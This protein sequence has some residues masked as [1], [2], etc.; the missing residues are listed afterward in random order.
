MKLK[1]LAPEFLRGVLSAKE[2]N[3]ENAL[4]RF[5]VKRMPLNFII[6]PDFISYDYTGLP[7]KS[8]KLPVIA[9]TVVDDLTAKKIKPFADNIIFENF[10]PKE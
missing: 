10:I 3:T 1:K 6:K 9:W 7:L 5:M 8:K 2:P 4:H